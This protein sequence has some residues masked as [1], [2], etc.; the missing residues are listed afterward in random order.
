MPT[1]CWP[2]YADSGSARTARP[3]PIY[4]DSGLAGLCRSLTGGAG[5]ITNNVTGATRSMFRL[6][7]AGDL[8]LSDAVSG[9][10][11]AGL[12]VTGLVDDIDGQARPIGAGIDIGADER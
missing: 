6:Q 10:V 3:W 7:A 1:T 2:V 12:A 5:N 9:V 8:H 4:A 11:D